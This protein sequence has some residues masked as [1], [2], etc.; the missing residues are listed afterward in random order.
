[1][2]IS[3]EDYL[4]CTQALLNLHKKLN[5]TLKEGDS[6]AI[7]ELNDIIQKEQEYLDQVFIDTH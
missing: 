4:A 1:M 3:R 2:V 7:T 6:V 5:S